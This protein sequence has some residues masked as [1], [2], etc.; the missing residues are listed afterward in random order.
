MKKILILS[1]ALGGLVFTGCK[2]RDSYNVSQLVVESHPVITFTGSKFVSIPVG[3]T[4][5]PI[6]VTAY[7]SFYNEVCQVTVGE[8][9]ID[10]TTPGLY[11]QEFIAKNSKGFRSTAAAYVAVTDVPASADLSGVY[12]RAG[13]NA[14]V[15][16]TKVANGLYQTD[17]LFG[18]PLGTPGGA[19]VNAYFVHINDSTI[20]MPD[21][22][23][24]LGTLQTD[25]VGLHLAPGDTTYS[26]K[27]YNL[28]S[29]NALRT[30]KKQ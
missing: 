24:D 26:Y 17:N 28:T 14:V 5:P 4:V 21:Q 9:V 11:F 1:I 12:K 8:S 30:F 2:K 23:T 19:Y 20:A 13:N 10:N 29:N 3:G 22:P 6:A 25:D 15:N 7:D 16:L 27:I 18:T